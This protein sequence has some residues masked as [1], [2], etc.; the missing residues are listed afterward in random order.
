MSIGER[1]DREER[2]GLLP[3]RGFLH[4]GVWRAGN[5]RGGRSEMSRGSWVEHG[6]LPTAR[7]TRG[8]CEAYPGNCHGYVDPLT[9]IKNC[10][11]EYHFDEKQPSSRSRRPPT[12]EHRIASVYPTPG[13]KVRLICRELAIPL[14]TRRRPS[15]RCSHGVLLDSSSRSINDESEIDH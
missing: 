7:Y 5:S 8:P 6:G 15:A 14:P 2:A 3:S 4:R 12:R 13:K 9:V 11:A 10:P 1:S